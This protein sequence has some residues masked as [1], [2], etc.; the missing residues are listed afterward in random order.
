MI[1][2]FL[3]LTAEHFCPACGDCLELLNNKKR[4]D[5]FFVV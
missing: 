1:E 3:E 2:I 5:I 4:F